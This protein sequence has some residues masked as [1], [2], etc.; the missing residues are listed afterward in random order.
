VFINKSFDV[1]QVNYQY[2][3]KFYDDF[4]MDEISE[5]IKYDVNAVLDYILADKSYENYYLIAKSLGTMAMSSVLERGS[6]KN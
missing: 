5:A 6:F 2:N 3:D 4:S 1:L